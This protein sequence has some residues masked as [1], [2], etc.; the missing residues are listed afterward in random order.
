ME[1]KVIRALN[2]VADPDL[3]IESKLHLDLEIEGMPWGG[4]GF[5]ITW[6]RQDVDKYITENYEDMLRQAQLNASQVITPKSE[7]RY[8]L[9]D[10]DKIPRNLEQEMD[11]VKARMDALEITP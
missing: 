4:G 3:G 5:P 7:M 6:T 1:Y 9:V 11:D 2:T 8:D 10:E